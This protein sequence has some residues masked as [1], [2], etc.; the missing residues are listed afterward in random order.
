MRNYVNSGNFIKR[1][2]I[3]LAVIG[4]NSCG[5]SGGGLD[6]SVPPEVGNLTPV[7]STVMMVGTNCRAEVITA[8]NGAKRYKSI[9]LNVY[10]DGSEQ[11]LNVV[12]TETPC[13]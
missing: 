8:P 13:P 1:L 7:D 4:L 5:A 6:P 11:V 10:S 9:Y 2:S 12:E 3:A